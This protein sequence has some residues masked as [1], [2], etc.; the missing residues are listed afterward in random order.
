M[1]IRIITIVFLILAFI[2]GCI[3]FE[4]KKGELIS[5]LDNVRSEH[6]SMISKQIRI[7][8]LKKKRAEYF[9]RV[10][11]INRPGDINRS[12]TGLISVLVMMDDRSVRFSEINIKSRTGAIEFEI[13]GYS[14]KTAF[15]LDLTD[16][17]ESSAGAFIISKTVSEKNPGEFI[18]RGE[19][20]AE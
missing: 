7:D 19:V 5:E 8:E 10:F 18:I 15:L 2:G 3:Y 16:K 9:E 12:L 20:A 11:M 4:K 6:S 17:L 1:K 14:R 13:T